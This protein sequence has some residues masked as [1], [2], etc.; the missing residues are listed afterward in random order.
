MK[1]FLIKVISLLP[2]SLQSFLARILS[3]IKKPNY[4]GMHIVPD[5]FVF[6]KYITFFQYYLI[7]EYLVKENLKT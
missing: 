4:I 6:L 1:K 3:F 2:N 7:S 5:N